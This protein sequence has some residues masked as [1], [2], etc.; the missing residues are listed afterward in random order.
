MPTKIQAKRALRIQA[1]TFQKFGRLTLMEPAEPRVTWSGCK[2]NRWK[3]RC[4]CGNEVIAD[5]S[6]IC[7]GHTASCG[8]FRVEHSTSKATK[9]GFILSRDPVMRRFHNRWVQMRQRC[10]NPNDRGYYKYGG[11]GIKVCERWRKFENFLA[12]MWPSFKPELSI[13][14]I[15]NNG[16]YEPGNCKWATAKEQANNRRLRKDSNKNRDNQMGAFV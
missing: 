4:A 12:D 7:S 5:E 3:C 11:R 1:L 14:R 6:N 13:E 2:I 8:C 9:H 10:E 16:N 15:N